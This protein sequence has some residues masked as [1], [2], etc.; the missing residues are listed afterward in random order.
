MILK[1]IKEGFIVWIFEDP[2]RFLKDLA[3]FLL[4]FG[5]RYYIDLCMD[6]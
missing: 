4:L 6:P 2:L 5:V 1:K 3:G